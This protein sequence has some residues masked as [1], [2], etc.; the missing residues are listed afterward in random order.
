MNKVTKVIIGTL[1]SPLSVGACA[2]ILQG[3]RYIRTSTVVRIHSITPRQVRF[4]TLNTQY[5]LL[6][7]DAPDGQAVIRRAAVSRRGA[8][9]RFLCGAAGVIQIQICIQNREA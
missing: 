1:M 8:A 9:V 4:E 7:P 2:L 6:V 3:G 5:C